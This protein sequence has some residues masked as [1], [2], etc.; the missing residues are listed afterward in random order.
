MSSES[1]IVGLSD[2][3]R[4]LIAIG[5]AAV[6][7]AVV[8]VYSRRQRT[9]LIPAI[10]VSKGH[11]WAY[12][13]S[14]IPRCCNVCELI[15]N[16]AQRC[17]SCQ[18]VA[19]HRCIKKADKTIPCKPLAA[20]GTSTKHH[21]VKGNLELG[22]L[23]SVCCKDCGMDEGLSDYRCCWC[24][25]NVH[26]NCRKD[27]PD[28]GNCDLGAYKDFIVPPNCVKLKAVGWKGRRRFVVKEVK[29]PVSDAWS[30]LIVIAN[31]KSGNNDGQRIL[32][33]F[34]S[35][36]NPVQ[37]IDLYEL[38]LEVALEWCHLIS[39]HVCR[40]IV[41]GGDGTI[42]WVLNTIDKLKLE[43]HPHVAIL[44]LGT[45]NDL[46]RVLGWG[47]GF[48][49]DIDVHDIFHRLEKSVKVDLD[50]WKVD[51]DPVSHVRLRHPKKKVFVNNYISVGVD[52]LVTLKFHQTRESKL[53]LFGS[54]VL[55]KLLFM[56][57]ATK[58]V[59]ERECKNLREKV[60]VWLDGTKIDLPDIE[61][62]I[63][64]NIPCWGAGV[65]PWTLGSSAATAP[66]QKIDDGLVEVFGV[67]S[68]FHI[69][70][71]QI[72]LSEPVRLGQAKEV[73]MVLSAN[74]PM[75]VDGEPWEQTPSE[76]HLS[77]HG[78]AAML[79]CQA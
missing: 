25:R 15:V 60:S 21:L 59:W 28:S 22:S 9:Y 5:T 35:I 26:E 2:T 8:A 64:L 44:P 29:P 72:G 52:A 13:E 71:M 24:G 53:Y 23:C 43:R 74:M 33:V 77:F 27:L 69:A 78:Q 34:R 49:G 40:I 79:S 67:Y 45:G 51:I 16:G 56:S 66:K 19:D 37:V 50:R 58:D 11:R 1:P 75:Q 7:T 12:D 48:S 70:Q 4:V 76:I 39:D 41:G 73:K 32:Q 47:E 3:Q 30:P 10:D 68:T 42:G 14:S 38:P 62:V 36:L 20:F 6:L 65:Q 54:R 55:N 63:V 46:S 17:E 18:V 57:F 61:A 31:R